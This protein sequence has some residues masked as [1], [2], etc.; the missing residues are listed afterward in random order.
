MYTIVLI[1]TIILGATFA[2]ICNVKKISD[3]D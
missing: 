3:C 1:E 2:D